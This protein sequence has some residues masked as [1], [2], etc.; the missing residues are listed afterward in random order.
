MKAV[1]KHTQEKWVILYIERWLKAP[2]QQRDGSMMPRD[3]GTPQ[4]SCISAVLSNLFLHYVFD[5]WMQRNRPNMLWCRYADDGA[6]RKLQFKPVEVRSWELAM[7][8]GSVDT[9]KVG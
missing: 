5:A 6:K 8:P 2:M 3:C 9:G 7:D 1:R 4:G